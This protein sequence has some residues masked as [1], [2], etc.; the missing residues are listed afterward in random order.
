[1][2]FY[3]CRVSAAFDIQMQQRLG[4][5]GAQVEASFA[6]IHADTIA[7]IDLVGQVGIV[8][9]E[10]FDC[11]VAITDLVIDFSAHRET[12]G[13]LVKH[14]RQ[15]ALPTVTSIDLLKKGAAGL[16]FNPAAPFYLKIVV[17]RVKSSRIF[18]HLNQVN[19]HLNSAEL[20][21]ATRQSDRPR[22]L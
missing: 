1:M 14:F 12:F 19:C 10:Q 17:I 16:K 2:L 8:C 21:R 22:G 20:M 13:T 4:I 5:V 11:R 15:A 9:F 3:Q 18:S 7:A 6:E